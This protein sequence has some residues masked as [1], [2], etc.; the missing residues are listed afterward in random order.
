MWK[1]GFASVA[2]T[3]HRKAALPCQDASRA[4]VFLDQNGQEVLI[5]AASDGAGSAAQAQLGAMFAAEFFVAGVKGHL[6]NGGDLE[7]LTR[8]FVENWIDAFQQTA[9][10][11]VI[12][13]G[14]I[15]DFACTLLAAIISSEG[16]CYFHL[17]DGAIVESRRGE[18]DLYHC[19]SWPQQGEYANTTHF[20]TDEDAARK[21]VVE[22]RSC[23]VDEIALFTDGLQNLVLDYR[24][25]SAHS[26]FFTPLF[27]QLRTQPN[28][29]S[30]EFSDSLAV[31][32][33]SE[34][35]NARTDD[36]KTLLVATRRTKP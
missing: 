25:R 18:N 16:V 33:N 8:T 15:Q 14:T 29:F 36:D 24:T 1:F 13:S 20:L 10:G 32:L 28:E 12:E 21:I 2:G 26:P 22:V 3:S 35:F 31:Y 9:N 30:Q 17:G 19:A 4:E 11:W 5:A 7:S 23:V 34:K 6:V 27:G